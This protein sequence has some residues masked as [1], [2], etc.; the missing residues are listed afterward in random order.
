MEGMPPPNPLL[1][2]FIGR[3]IRSRLVLGH[4]VLTP[5][6]VQPRRTTLPSTAP[7]AMTVTSWFDAVVGLR[8]TGRVSTPGSGHERFLG[9]GRPR[10]LVWLL[11]APLVAERR[12]LVSKGWL[13]RGVPTSTA[14]N[15]RKI[16]LVLAAAD[17]VGRRHIA[18]RVSTS[19]QGRVTLGLGQDPWTHRQIFS[20]MVA[21][22]ARRGLSP[23]SL[24]RAFLGFRLVFIPHIAPA[25]GNGIL[26]LSKNH[27]HGGDGSG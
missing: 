12:P 11:V 6:L 8:R 27:G 16:V 5:I 19:I 14:L 9:V 23:F 7:A 13:G 4:G 3:A 21:P 1:V 24:H 10:F 18:F 17:L 22:T 15:S 26:L 25:L 2:I 20:A